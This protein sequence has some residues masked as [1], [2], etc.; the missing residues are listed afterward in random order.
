MVEAGEKGEKAGR[1]E[2]WR[3]LVVEV[4]MQLGCDG[5][6]FTGGGKP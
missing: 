4:V 2:C 1:S 6:L 3:E 5:G